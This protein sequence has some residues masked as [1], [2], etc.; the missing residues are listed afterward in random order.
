M[1]VEMRQI[2]GVA[3]RFKVTLAADVYCRRYGADR[4]PKDWTKVRPE[5]GRVTVTG[6]DGKRT[7]VRCDALA[8]RAWPECAAEILARS[9]VVKPDPVA[10]RAR[11]ALAACR[12]AVGAA[13]VAVGACGPLPELLPTVVEI[14]ERTSAMLARASGAS[15]APDGSAWLLSV[16]CDVLGVQRVAADLQSGVGAI[17]AWRTGG[18]VPAGLVRA[19]ERLGALALARRHGLLDDLAS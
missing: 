9:I 4:G 1:T 18:F 7:T 5:N 10:T 17:G 15:P 19:V 16:A 12:G 8:A 13:E 11:E 2:P 14:H 3:D 6:L